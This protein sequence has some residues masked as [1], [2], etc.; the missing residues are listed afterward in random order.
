MLANRIIRENKVHLNRLF[1]KY[2]SSMSLLVL[3]FNFAIEPQIYLI[4]YKSFTFKEVCY[5]VLLAIQMWNL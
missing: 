3:I 2:Y 5:I 4:D 1:I